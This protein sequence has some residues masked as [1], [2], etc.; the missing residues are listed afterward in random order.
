METDWQKEL[1]PVWHKRW[2]A[3]PPDVAC[4]EGM[5][6]VC[7]CFDDWERSRS[8]HPQHPQCPTGASMNGKG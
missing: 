1:I 8:G 5:S 4:R 3:T 2:L 7:R 6:S